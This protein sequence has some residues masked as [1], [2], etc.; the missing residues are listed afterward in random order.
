MDTQKDESLPLLKSP[1]VALHSAR[2][3]TFDTDDRFDFASSTY[4]DK[5]WG[6]VW[7]AHSLFILTIYRCVIF[8]VLL[9]LH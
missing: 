2:L 8:S 9:I 5:I 1:P 4:K 6:V 3:S 7:I